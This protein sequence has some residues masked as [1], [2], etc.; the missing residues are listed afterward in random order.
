MQYYSITICHSHR[1]GQKKG[2]VSVKIYVDVHYVY[3]YRLKKVTTHCYYCGLVPD[4]Q[5]SI[6]G[7]DSHHSDLQL[8]TCN[9]G[10]FHPCLLNNALH[11]S[12]TRSL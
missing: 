10:H 3:I 7:D 8:Y 4:K 5:I 1:K 9:T 11:C 12:F 6:V 2:D